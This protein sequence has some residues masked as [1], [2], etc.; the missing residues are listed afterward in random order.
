MLCKY[1][2]VLPSVTIFLPVDLYCYYLKIKERLYKFNL[3][4][5]NLIK[6]PMQLEPKLHNLISYYNLDQYLKV[7]V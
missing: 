1:Y 3:K 2:I 5:Y 6:K 7:S 4:P